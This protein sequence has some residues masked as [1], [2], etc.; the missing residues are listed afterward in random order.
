M[1]TSS[2]IYTYP[3]FCTK[4]G[5]ILPPLSMEEFLKCYSCKTVYGPEIYGDAISEYEIVLNSIED[6]DTVVK[7]EN[8]DDADDGPIA[9]RRCNACGHNQMSYAAM[10][11]RSADEGQT[12]FYTCV[13]C[14][15]TEAENS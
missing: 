11:L 4:C 13:K 6:L 2:N 9:E 14:K 5:S 15:F 7:T 10:Q 3:G 12:V 1:E 8:R